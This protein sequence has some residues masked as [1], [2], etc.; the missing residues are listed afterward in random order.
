MLFEEVSKH[1]KEDIG[2]HLSL[3][4]NTIETLKLEN[5][6]QNKEIQALKQTQAA[7]FDRLDQLGNVEKEDSPFTNEY[8]WKIYDYQKRVERSAYDCEYMLTRNFYTLKGHKLKIT[9]Y[10][11]GYKDLIN[12]HAAIYFQSDEGSFDD[13]LKWPMKVLIEYSAV[14]QNEL[15]VYSNSFDTCYGVGTS[16]QKP[17]HWDDGWGSNDFFPV[18]YAPV[19]NNTLVLKVKITYL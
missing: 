9:F 14:D 15:A 11:N 2:Q 17:P 10:P 4:I 12:T 19:Q 16:F 3:A 5:K 18:N 6:A 13:T 8:T 1:D 7:I